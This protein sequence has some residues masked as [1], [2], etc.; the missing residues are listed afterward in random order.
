MRRGPRRVLNAAIRRVNPRSTVGV[1]WKRQG[2]FITFEW[3]GFVEAPT[4]PLLFGR[5]HYESQV[6]RELLGPGP[7]GRVLEI[8]CGFG[9]LSPVFAELATEH[10]GVDINAEALAAARATYPALEFRE[11]SVTDLPFDDGSFDVVVTWTVLQHLPPG[12]VD[13]ALAEVRRV[14]V[15]AGRV[16][17]CEETF[18][19]DGRTHH[20]WHRPPEFYAEALAPLPLRHSAYIDAID[21]LPGL[22]SPGRVML[23][24]DGAPQ[25]ARAV[26]GSARRLH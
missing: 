25:D 26:A 24:G 5:H 4:I 22:R 8:G 10:V 12:L 17:L 20:S 9:R 21:D 14:L 6:I 7:A 2:E 23:F 11:A 3:D 18:D 19:P 1:P 15:P 13:D 16:L